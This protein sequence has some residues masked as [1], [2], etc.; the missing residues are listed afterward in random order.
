MYLSALPLSCDIVGARLGLVEN[1]IAF[2][3]Q[4]FEH[5]VA[6]RRQ[7]TA[8]T[9]RHDDGSVNSGCNPKH[10]A[11]HHNRKSS[12]TLLIRTLEG[13]KN[14]IGMRMTI[15]HLPSSNSREHDPAP[16]VQQHIVIRAGNRMC[17]LAGL[18]MVM[19]TFHVSIRFQKRTL[20]H[21]WTSCAILDK[22]PT[23]AGRFAPAFESL[24]KQTF[25]LSRKPI[26]DWVSAAL[27][28]H[29]LTKADH[30]AAAPERFFSRTVAKSRKASS[31]EQCMQASP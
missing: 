2:C 30:F 13:H 23:K 6:H 18:G 3:Y 31:C 29:T 26:H 21:V 24:F 17:S 11:S 28:G 7:T 25:A 15:S 16:H 8:R 9:R 27:L 19:V 22:T 1:H 20:I 4:V 10:V 5:T 12:L 14:C